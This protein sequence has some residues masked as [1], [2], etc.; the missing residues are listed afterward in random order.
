MCFPLPFEFGKNILWRRNN[1]SSVP[2]PA[3]VNNEP[4]PSEFKQ[5]SLVQM[6]IVDKGHLQ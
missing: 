3:C 4:K 5:R 2:A 1:F 6:D